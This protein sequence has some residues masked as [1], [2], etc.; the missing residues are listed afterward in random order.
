MQETSFSYVTS[1]RSGEHRIGRTFLTLRLIG[2]K[3][4]KK[5]A[6]STIL[7]MKVRIRKF[8]CHKK[9]PWVRFAGNDISNYGLI[10]NTADSRK[11]L[12]FLIKIIF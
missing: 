2:C 11:K 8:K 6:K 9:I 10:L 7:N 12:K 3:S 1:P 5:C 4:T